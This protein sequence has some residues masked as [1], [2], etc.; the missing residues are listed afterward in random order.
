MKDWMMKMENKIPD[1]LDDG[2]RGLIYAGDVDFICNW[3]G[4]FH[5]LIDTY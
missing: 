2:I 3:M 5:V 1:M 4:T